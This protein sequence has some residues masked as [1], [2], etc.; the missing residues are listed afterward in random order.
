M[1]QGVSVSYL[2]KTQNYLNVTKSKVYK[3][4]RF[5]FT[6]TISLLS[7]YKVSGIE[8]LVVVCPGG[9]GD[10]GGGGVCVCVK[11]NTLT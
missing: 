11:K 7:C 1:G 6:T 9:G 8:G 4:F 2:V 10:G 5:D 3:V